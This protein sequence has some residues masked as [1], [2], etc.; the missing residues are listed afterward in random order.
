[1]P[2]IPLALQL[3]STFV[4]MAA[5][6][7][8]KLIAGEKGE[9]VAQQV[10]SMAETL[11]GAKGPAVLD[12]LK[13]DP[14]LV[15]QYQSQLMQYQVD[16]FK[17]EIS[18]ERDVIVAEAQSE[19]WITRNWRPITM[20]TFVALLVAKWFGWTAPGISEA[21]QLALMEII[22]YGLSGYVAG[23][24]AEKIAPMLAGMFSKK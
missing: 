24:S 5:P 11:T 9:A 22:K 14:A 13:Q 7:L 1:M 8:G 18:A 15:L 21:E 4:P 23:R 10:V 17:T 16:A 2:L 19:S 12:A 20:L 6:A 3:L